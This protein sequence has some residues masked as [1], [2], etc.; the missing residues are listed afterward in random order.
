MKPG[1]SPQQSLGQ[2]LQIRQTHRLTLRQQQSIRLLQLSSAEL[3]TEILDK[4]ESNIM[5]EPEGAGQATEEQ[6]PGA[7]VASDAG[8]LSAGDGQLPEQ[9]DPGDGPGDGTGQMSAG[10]GAQAPETGVSDDFVQQFFSG[11]LDIDMDAL[12]EQGPVPVQSTAERRPDV[13]EYRDLSA[14][15]LHE[16]L[17]EQLQVMPLP[18]D[19]RVLATAVIQA[20]D[21]DGFLRCPLEELQ[22]QGVT[23]GQLEK[24]LELVQSLDPPGIA[25]RDLQEC[26]LLQLREYPQ[27]TPALDAARHIVQTGLA[28][29]QGQQ[30]SQLAKKLGLAAADIEAALALLQCLNPRPGRLF[31]GRGIEYITPDLF[32]EQ[33]DE[34]TWQ[35]KLNE[36]LYPGLRINPYYRRLLRRRARQVADQQRDLLRNHLEEAKWFKRAL[37]NR[38]DT[39][40][41]VA[42]CIVDHQVDFFRPGGGDLRPLVLREIARTLEMHT[43]TVSRAVSGKYMQTPRGTFELRYFFSSAVSGGKGAPCSSRL[44]CDRLEQLVRAENPSHPLSDSKIVDLLSAQGISVARR[45]IAKYRDSLR[46]PSASQRRQRSIV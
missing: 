24:A 42:E 2:Q 39:L 18:D 34:S 10:D 38:G 13:W 45:T 46:I 8:D 21:E 5:L 37:Q 28:R 1:A 11:E 4:L 16:Q 17:L 41:R 9:R 33:V 20:L 7:A 22:E 27:D 35:V 12:Y 43:S 30:R 36:E 32:L 31:D 44:V 6:D 19:E 25:A 23:R 26:L 3:R 29:L 40:R 15:S 14:P